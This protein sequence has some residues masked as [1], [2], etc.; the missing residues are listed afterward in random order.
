[1]FAWLFATLFANANFVAHA[2]DD[3]VSFC[4]CVSFLFFVPNV[5]AEVL[6]EASIVIGSVQTTTRIYMLLHHQYNLFMHL[7]SNNNQTRLP[8]TRYNQI[9]QHCL[10]IAVT[11][12]PQAL[13][14]MF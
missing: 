1:M 13:Q 9:Q 2:I 6:N 5:I 4:L 10:A 14:A 3:V 11:A 12:M 7:H 8:S